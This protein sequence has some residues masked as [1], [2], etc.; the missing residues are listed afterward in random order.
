MR[1]LENDYSFQGKKVF[2]PH[3]EDFF[4][5]M[6]YACEN[7]NPLTST[8]GRRCLRDMVRLISSTAFVKNQI[9][10]VPSCY[11]LLASSN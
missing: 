10:I 6:F 1:V 7:E 3:L 4:E 8:S 2:K 5:A 11:I 9:E